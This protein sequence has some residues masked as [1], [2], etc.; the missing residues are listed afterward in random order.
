[1]LV[2]TTTGTVRVLP[3]QHHHGLE[4]DHQRN[5]TIRVRP[6]RGANEAGTA[7]GSPVEPPTMNVTP[8]NTLGEGQTMSNSHGSAIIIIAAILIPL[9]STAMR[10]FF[11]V[12]SF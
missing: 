8:T 11:S 9:G 1:M 3:G 7:G 12:C 4:R 5:T 10:I 2:M 6:V